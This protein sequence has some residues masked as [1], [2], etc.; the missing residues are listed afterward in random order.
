VPHNRL[1]RWL[2]W[3]CALF[4]YRLLD[5]Q[6]D[7]EA[8]WTRF[9][10]CNVSLK[11]ELFM[12]SGGFDPEF[13]FDYEDLD[14]GWRLS[15]CDMRLLYEPAAVVEHLHPYDWRAV[16]RRYVSRAGA[17]RLMAAKHDWFQP[18]FREQ[19]ETAV[20]EPRV[21]RLWTFAVDRI[22]LRA[23]RV[24]RAVEKRA[25]CHY[26][27]RLAPL[28]LEAWAEEAASTSPARSTGP[29]APESR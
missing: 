12:A 23:G 14:L 16:E 29:R 25:D 4:D 1:H 17:E 10:S 22:P 26:R 19:M 6:G 20:R 13:V 3:S 2:D 24:R 8:G 9:Y 27:Q 7:R 21:S 5:D 28:F 18:W 15:E 11:R